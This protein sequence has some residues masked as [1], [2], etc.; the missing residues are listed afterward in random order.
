MF[1][2]IEDLMGAGFPRAVVERLGDSFGERLLPLQRH[3]LERGGLLDGDEGL[4]V[5][6]PT[7]SGKTLV[8]ELA[9]LRGLLRGRP[10]L[11][12]A[13]TRALAWEKF[14]QFRERYGPLG[15]RV[16]CSTGEHR[17]DDTAIA[18]GDVGIAACVYEKGLALAARGQGSGMGAYGVLVADELQLLGDAGR[19]AAVDVLLARWRGLEARRRPRLVALSAVLPQPESLAS[20]L[21]VRLVSATERVAPLREGV[22]HLGTGMYTWRERRS[23]ERGEERLA[24]AGGGDAE[25]LCALAGLARDFGPVIAFCAT[26]R[27][28][29]SAAQRVADGRLLGDCAAAR[30]RLGR[31]PFDS[32]RDLLDC[33]LAGGVAVHTADL[34]LAQR[35]VVERA[36]DAGEIPLLFATPTLDQGVD[37]CAA[38]VVHAPVM[39]DGPGGGRAPLSAGRYINQAGRAGRRGVLGRSV[40]LAANDFEE[41]RCWTAVIDALVEPIRSPLC[42]ASVGRW[43]GYAACGDG[44][45]AREEAVRF[46][47]RTYASAGS[48]VAEGAWRDAVEEAVTEGVAAGRL[49]LDATG[50][51]RP[52]GYGEAVW[53]A[54]I[55]PATAE[56]WRTFLAGVEHRPARFACVSLAALAEDWPPVAP[57]VSG[58]DQR[59]NAWPRGVV[60]RLDGADIL[61]A[62]LAGRFAPRDGAPGREHA[63][64]RRALLLDDW[65]AG[66]DVAILETVHR[67]TAGQLERL[68]AQGAWLLSALASVAGA[69]GLAPGVVVAFEDT[70]EALARRARP[71]I[72]DGEPFHADARVEPSA[73]EAVGPDPG[74]EGGIR[75]V[76]AEARQG[77]AR[78]DGREV[79]LTPMPY[80]LLRLLAS[81]AGEV[82]PYQVIRDTLWPD[83]VVE[84]QQ[85][86]QHRR[87][88]ERDLGCPPRSLV[89]VHDGFG[90]EL[91]LDPGAIRVDGRDAGHV[92]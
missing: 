88:L 41:A 17:R 3:A 79:K 27:E 56:T 14:E 70:A 28:A 77:F 43:L 13:P 68:A 30:S 10:A 12:L 82:V 57:A 48:G 47:A 86:R 40:L 42:P 72:A 63:A 44:T 87:R 90:L 89:D 69:M 60:E 83:A 32:V 15:I 8:A 59:R 45:V 25:P 65:I 51:L 78:F 91:L 84:D 73:P 61:T 18:A 4:L 9:M 5:S 11:Y 39:V 66:E 64:A 85:L 21:G 53:A 75:L 23:G 80:A 36:F 71:T 54:G 22:L 1:T 2:M 67:L 24:E 16:A 7:A 74:G 20:W 31:M 33:T 26:R 76:L 29:F 37:L 46:F 92:A 58:F 49:A 62:R 55:S 34:T 81:R 35:Q 38:T 52:T 19:G 6:A 50:V